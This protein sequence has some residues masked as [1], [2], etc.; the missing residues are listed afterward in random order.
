MTRQRSRWIV[1]GLMLAATL[2]LWLWFGR[3]P[4]KRP[5]QEVAAPVSRILPANAGERGNTI[6]PE[7]EPEETTDDADDAN[8]P[9][10]EDVEAMARFFAPD[11]PRRIED[12]AVVWQKDTDRY[13][14]VLGEESFEV[15]AYRTYG[16]SELL[17]VLG[18]FPIF[19]PG[20]ASIVKLLARTR[21]FGKLLREIDEAR[22][23]EALPAKVE[24]LSKVVGRFVTERDLT[25]QK[26]KVLA[27]ERPD[28]FSSD[29]KI[30]D[31]D[32]NKLVD[33]MQGYAFSAPGPPDHLIPV[34]LRGTAIGL[35]A[36]VFLLGYTERPEA[37]DPILRVVAY[38]EA[39]HRQRVLDAFTPPPRYFRP[40]SPHNPYV[41]GDAL[42][43][44]LCAA[45][46]NT[47]IRDEA[48]AVARAYV[49]WRQ[50]LEWPDRREVQLYPYDMK[51]E[52]PYSYRGMVVAVAPDVPKPPLRE[53]ALLL[54]LAFGKD[55]YSEERPAVTD[56]IVEW[57]R[58]FQ[59]ARQITQ[60]D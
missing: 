2:V 19:R 28:R 43:R 40:A 33:L 57:A 11:G 37:V 14:K 46:A 30:S 48:Q 24:S 8:L 55:S 35:A 23:R 5:Q 45:A 4:D 41:I 38:D 22:A 10:A 21:R 60:V 44:I 25:Y 54:P 34:S 1:V 51:T 56:E 53:E 32:R 36:N 29:T 16:T 13:L 39:A 18:S 3:A 27:R 7:E 47:Q 17:T 59:Q 50:S 58:R 49:E 20:S 31:K 6:P 26:L 42:D 52:N 9:V 12:A 15:S